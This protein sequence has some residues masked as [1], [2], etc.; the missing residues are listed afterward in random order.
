MARQASG[1]T[2]PDWTSHPGNQTA[3]FTELTQA[4]PNPVINRPEIEVDGAKTRILIER[5][6]AVDSQRL[7][8]FAGRLDAQEL[9][10]V[11]DALRL[12]LA[13]R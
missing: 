11:D 3:G 6:M 5:T 2:G 10:A 1:G 4:E 13:L 7:G 12:V 8:D 9:T